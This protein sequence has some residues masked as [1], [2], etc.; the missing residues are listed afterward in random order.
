VTKE[1]RPRDAVERE[2]DEGRALL[3]LI[4]DSVDP[5]RVVQIEDFDT[6]PCGG[7]H[8]SS[9]G[10]IGRVRITDCTSKG[11]QVQRIEFELS[12]P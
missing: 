9:L 3:G 10:E 7:T 11:D 5:L 12:E 6:C 2:V 1:N 4:P 8:V